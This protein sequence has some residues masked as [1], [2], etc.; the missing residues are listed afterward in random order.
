MGN[1]GRNGGQF[2]TPRPLIRTMIKVIDPKVGE[3]IYDP[4]LILGFPCEAYGY[5]KDRM[6]K[7]QIVLHNYKK[8]HFTEKKKEPCICHWCYE[9]DF[10]WN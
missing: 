2:G 3:T 6:E 7:P 8:T 10:T 1:A 9:Y 5:I 4:A